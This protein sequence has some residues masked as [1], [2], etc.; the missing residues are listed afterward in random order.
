MAI[1]RQ[2]KQPGLSG[3]G[4]WNLHERPQ[5]PDWQSG[6]A[7]YP[8][9]SLGYY[10]ELIIGRKI[11]DRLTLQLSPT[12]VHRNIVDNKLIPNELFAVGFG[13]R[14]KFTL[15]LAIVW[16]CRCVINRFPDDK[17]AQHLVHRIGHRNGRRRFSTPCFQC[18]RDERTGLTSATRPPNHHLSRN[19]QQIPIH[20][21]E[22]TKTLTKIW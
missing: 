19:Q 14:V 2:Q 8:V 15:Q 4:W 22:K 9:R 21:T 17:L 20:K 12:W 13:G 16:D 11:T 6:S 7:G 5:R 10:H 18:S 3:L 1:E